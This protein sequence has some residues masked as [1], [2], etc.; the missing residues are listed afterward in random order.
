MLYFFQLAAQNQTLDLPSQI[1]NLD[2]PSETILSSI[3]EVQLPEDPSN[4]LQQL[5]MTDIVLTTNENEAVPSL[6]LEDVSF[7]DLNPVANN[8]QIISLPEVDGRVT[9]SIK[10]NTENGLNEGKSRYLFLK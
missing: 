9:I 5:Q 10:E 1:V 6:I 2:I 8:L 3:P 4:L 7:L